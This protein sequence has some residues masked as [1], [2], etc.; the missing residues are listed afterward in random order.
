MLTLAAIGAAAL[1][2][3]GDNPMHVNTGRAVFGRKDAGGTPAAGGTDISAD[4]LQARIEAAVKSALA[5]APSA[6]TPAQIAEAVK[7]AMT[8]APGAGTPAGGTPAAGGTE[9]E[10]ARISEIAVKAIEKILDG[11]RFKSRL[12][13]SPGAKSEI[14]IPCSLSKGNLPLHMKQLLNVAM[15]RKMDEG[16]TAEELTKGTEIGNKELIGMKSD[17][18][19][20]LTPTTVANWIPRDLSAE[21]YRRMY[22]TSAIAQAFMAGEIAMPTDPFDYPLVKGTGDFYLDNAGGDGS[23]A[24]P[25]DPDIGK[26]TLST[27]TFRG[28]RQLTDNAEED[29]IIALLP[30]LE[31][32]LAD[33]ARRAYESALINGDTTSTHQDSDVTG[34]KDARKAW[35]GFRKLA[36]E[37]NLKLDMSTGGLNRANLTSLKK[38]LGKW[39]ADTSNLLWIWGPMA[40]ATLGGLDEFALAYARGGPTTFGDGAPKPAPYGGQWAV[41]EAMREDLNASGVYDGSTTTKGSVLIV[42]RPSFV[43]GY[44]RQFK[45]ELDRNARA[46]LWDIIASF[47]RAFQP[48]ETPSSTIKT[49]QI[50]YNYTA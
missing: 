14:E 23:N 47:R 35:K 26:F 49:V 18:V 20:A 30:E 22:L 44:R 28:L 21:I 3:H 2:A 45:F 5:G 29:S 31:R 19:K 8:P 10:Q 7:A 34:P 33:S 24:T 1:T 17:G 40:D 13:G 50:G 16:I 46:G 48:V 11:D 4:A 43:C 12:P 38:G 32:D 15:N 6:A 25:S 37:A 42:H 39:G 41:S 36:L 9:A 27:R